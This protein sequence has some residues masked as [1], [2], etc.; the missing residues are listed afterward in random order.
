MKD[1][2]PAA[3]IREFVRQTFLADD[4]ADGD[5]FLQTGIIDS[6]GMLELITFVENRFGL[7]IQETELLP[8]NLDSIAN[9]VAFIEQKRALPRAS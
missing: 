3:Q 6:T 4:F 8:A 7:T 9:L 2:D 5:S 1:M